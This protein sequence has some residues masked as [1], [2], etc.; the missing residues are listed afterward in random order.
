MVKGKF[1]SASGLNQ[2]WGFKPRLYQVVSMG[3]LH[4]FTKEFQLYI[5]LCENDYTFHVI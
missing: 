4:Q 1:D 3:Q 2:G 5:S